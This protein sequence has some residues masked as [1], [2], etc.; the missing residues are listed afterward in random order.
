PQWNP[1]IDVLAV[2]EQRALRMLRLSGG[3]TIW[4]H[5]LSEGMHKPVSTDTS[6]HLLIRA[7]AWH[8]AG[9]RIAVL[10]ANGQIVHRDPA[11]GDIVHKSSIGIAINERVVDMQWLACT[12]PAP[13]SLNKV[14]L[15]LEFYLPTL[16]SF[17]KSK[18]APDNINPNDE[19]LSVIVATTETGSVWIALL[20]R[21]TGQ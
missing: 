10:H 20:G 12:S 7:I 6:D 9:S 11:R 13:G 4:R 14:D 8:P 21:T 5:A 18:S 19:P 1:A 15:P 3:Q 16:S 2:P 17:D